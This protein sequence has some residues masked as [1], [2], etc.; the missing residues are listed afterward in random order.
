V[1]VRELREG[2]AGLTARLRE[3]AFTRVPGLTG[4]IRHLVSVRIM[5][6][7][8]VLAAK[9]FTTVLP[10]IFVIVAFSPD[11]LKD[12]F[13]GAIRGA[14]GLDGAALQQVDSALTAPDGDV[15]QAYGL[16]GLVIVLYSA[17][18]FSR[19]LQ[20]LCER[21]WYLPKATAKEV[22]WRWPAWIG[23]L[24]V[25]LMVAGVLRRGLG[26]GPVAGMFLT[27]PVSIG[28]WWWTQ[29]FLL[30]GRIG[31]PPLLPGAVL[32]GVALTLWMPAS[33]IYVPEALN[34][35]ISR[36]GPLGSVF[37]ILSWLL[38]I[39]S[40]VTGCLAAGYVVAHWPPFDRRLNP[41]PGRFP[42]FSARRER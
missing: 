26:A 37:T 10:V 27:A 24:V 25:C 15:R 3:S 11:G 7:A 14:L 2:A 35:S 23:G 28:F 22:A 32:T 9:A 30:A 41:P 13:K 16:V 40:I 19:S 17:T 8:T 18:S 34:R 29:R 33:R 6:S 31:W 39:T 20:K 42:P 38:T 4:I 1:G 36:Y 5:D 12:R 21:C